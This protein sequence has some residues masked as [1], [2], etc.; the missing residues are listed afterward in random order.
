MVIQAGGEG[1]DSPAGAGCC[2]FQLRR[3]GIKAFPARLAAEAPKRPAALAHGMRQGW[4]DPDG[5]GRG[6]VLVTGRRGV[7]TQPRKAGFNASLAIPGPPRLGA[8]AAVN[9]GR[10]DNGR[11]WATGRL[12]RIQQARRAPK[13]GQL[14]RRCGRPESQPAGCGCKRTKAAKAV[15]RNCVT[16]LGAQRQ[17]SQRFCS[18]A[19]DSAGS[20]GTLKAGPDRAGREMQP[21]HALADA[22]PGRASAKEARRLTVG[23]RCVKSAQGTR[24]TSGRPSRPRISGRLRQSQAGV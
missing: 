21:G 23:I 2:R 24:E 22:Q 13:G 20:G 17:R 5:T 18:A 16:G 4:R 19:Q 11:Q 10:R 12:A 1:R 8:V 14:R 9:G 3:A 7:I 15:N 6:A